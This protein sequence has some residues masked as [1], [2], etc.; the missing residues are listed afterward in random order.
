M[1]NKTAISFISGVLGFVLLAPTAFAATVQSDLAEQKSTISAIKK[2]LPAVVS[3][4]VSGEKTSAL[5]NLNTGETKTTKERVQL[6]SGTGFLVSSNG[7]IVTNKHVVSIGD[8]Q[9]PDFRVKMSNGKKYRAQLIGKDPT[10]DLA[11]LKI[12]DSKL[13]YVQLGDSKQLELGQTAIAIGNALGVYA[14]SVTKGIV[15]GL[16]RSI[17]AS[18]SGNNNELESLTNVIQTDAEINLGNS[19]GPLIDLDG[20][21]IGVNVAT[22]VGGKSLGFAI[23]INDVKPIIKTANS[24]HRIVRPRLGVRYIALNV[25]TAEQLGVAETRGVLIKGGESNAPPAVV[26]NSPAARA[27]LRNGDI[28]L[29][30]DGKKITEEDTMAQLISNYRPGQR[31]GLR[32]K[33]DG[34]IFSQVLVLDQFPQEL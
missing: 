7:F 9:S 19:G 4:S 20:K 33:R 5:V 17:V 26:P 34:R 18:D 21:V 30:V 1:T 31:I 25:D 13:P 10:N 12:F 28:I 24:E 14:N 2:V 32:I 11:I 27:G 29:E 16:H 6:G 8:R 3:I 22:D 15:S 23:P